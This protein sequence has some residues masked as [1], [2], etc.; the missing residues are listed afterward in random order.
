MLC[1]IIRCLLICTISIGIISCKS[2]KDI[3]TLQQKDNKYIY[4]EGQGVSFDVAKQYAIQDLTTNL[5]VSIKYSLQNTTQQENN[6]LQTK[7]MSNIR[8][9]SQ[10]KDLPSVEVDK[11]KKSKDKVFVRVKV[12]QSIL[13]SEIYNRVQFKKQ[14][15][16]SMITQCDT[17]SFSNF[18]VFKTLL[19]DLTSDIS[20]Y[21]ALAEN[22]DYGNNI[23]ASLQ[24]SISTKPKYRILWNNK[25]QYNANEIQDIIASEIAKFI[26]IDKDSKRDLIIDINS[27]DKTIVIFLKFYD[28]D[29]N[30][31]NAIQIDTYMQQSSIKMSSS[32]SRLG[33][34]IYK[35]IEAHY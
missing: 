14:K 17:P 20:L 33:A 2:A 9:E 1:S 15:L 18:R 27:N 21:Q 7:A 3:D 28:C 31:E 30:M 16:L 26:K 29:K 24:D 22:M 25:H 8:L 34:I 19:K 23:L 10:I 32:K 13:K 35:A 11:I 6:V 4:G 12:K 5:K